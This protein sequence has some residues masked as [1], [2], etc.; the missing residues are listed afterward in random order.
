[1]EKAVEIYV[2]V[3]FLVI[4][5]SHIFQHQAWAEFFDQLKAKG[6]PGAFING[7]LSLSA[8]TIIVSFHNVWTGPAT[9]L[10]VLGWSYV[11]K[12]LVAFV[13]PK[14]GLKSMSNVGLDTSRRFIIPGFIMVIVSGI[15]AYSLLFR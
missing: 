8:G 3:N 12:A 9:I 4:G 11:L 13:F 15:L 6:R 10:T 2:A 1:M 5:L 14:W 7:L